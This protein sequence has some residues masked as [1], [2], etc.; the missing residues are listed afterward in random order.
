MAAI[1]KDL[2]IAF[3]ELIH[4]AANVVYPYSTF[5]HSIAAKGRVYQA[6]N[7]TIVSSDIRPILHSTP[8]PLPNGYNY[9]RWPSVYYQSKETNVYRVT[10][11]PDDITLVGSATLT[12]YDKLHDAN[13]PSDIDMVWWP[14]IC[15]SI[16][17]DVDHVLI[18][19]P[20]IQTLIDEFIIA[21]NTRPLPNGISIHAYRLESLN[22]YRR[23]R[24]DFMYIGG[25]SH[26]V[27]DYTIEGRTYIQL[28]DISIH[29]GAS[30]QR[31]EVDGTYNA[32]LKRMIHDPIYC[33]VANTT[34]IENVRIPTLMHF[35]LQQLYLYANKLKNNDTYRSNVIYRR[36][37]HIKNSL[38]TFHSESSHSLIYMISYGL[39]HPFIIVPDSI[40][41]RRV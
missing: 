29:D 26:V 40:T 3:Y 23:Y 30:S 35:I 31:M 15:P 20:A 32:T 28:C 33:T 39:D 6:S 4:D 17:S 16:Q 12:L 37:I 14:S 10:Y 9:S 22:R 2:V 36:L 34:M 41:Y 18:T 38:L 11:N 27:I 13:Q 21:L 5:H 1:T 24:S 8:Q 7:K 19:S 25:V